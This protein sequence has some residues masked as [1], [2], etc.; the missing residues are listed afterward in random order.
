[1]LKYILLVE[2]FMSD[3]QSLLHDFSGPPHNIITIMFAHHFYRLSTHGDVY[4]KVKP[5]FFLHHD[6]DYHSG[7][8]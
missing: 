8:Q 5:S 7:F 1:M 2:Q 3:L 4:V 6:G